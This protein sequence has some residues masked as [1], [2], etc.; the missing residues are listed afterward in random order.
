MKDYQG[1]ID[2]L[3]D[4]IYS[5][6][7]YRLESSHIRDICTA[8][9]VNVG[10]LLDIAC[11]TGEHMKYLQEGFSV[12]G[13]DISEKM[14]EIASRKMPGKKF[15]VADMRNF[16]LGG[17]YDVVLC[18]FSSIAY[19]ESDTELVAT[20][21]NMK[22][23]LRDGG[24]MVIEP[25][26]LDETQYGV[27]ASLI[28]SESDSISLARASQGRFSNG[29]YELEFDYFI[30]DKKRKEV[31]RHNE[32]HSLMHIAEEAFF[33]FAK[34]AGMKC[35]FLQEGLKAGKGLFIFKKG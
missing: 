29:R 16:D 10:V 35:I 7:N 12:E 6:K 3:Y 13:L 26:F 9:G 34:N 4:L 23:H 1:N 33:Q 28:A 27:S 20:L 21:N 24:V 32:T 31:F 19:V 2:D 17:R 30:V 5:W 18:L 15:H 25:H 14:V 22:N 8:F 11:G